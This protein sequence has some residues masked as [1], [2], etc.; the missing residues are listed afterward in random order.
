V[1][2]S[3]NMTDKEPLFRHMIVCICC[4]STI[5]IT[6]GIASLLVCHL[7]RYQIA[8]KLI[9]NKVSAREA[10]ERAFKVNLY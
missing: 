4:T 6:L 1:F 10:V 2:E 9:K 8:A 7:L 3:Q 5:I